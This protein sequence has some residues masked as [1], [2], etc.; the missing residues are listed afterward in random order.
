[1]KKIY[2]SLLVFLALNTALLSK[3]FLITE[4]GAVR[5]QNSTTAIQKAVDECSASGGGRV[6]VPPGLYITG[7]VFL[8]SNVTFHLENG[9]VLKGSTYL[10][11]YRA[12]DTL[13]G[14]FY[15]EDAFNISFTG[16][17]TIDASGTGFYDPTKNHLW[18]EFDRN[19]IRQRNDYMPEGKFFTDGPIKRTGAPGM[20]IVFFHCTK[21]SLRDITIKDTPVW[22]TRFGYCEDVLIDGITILNNILVPNSDGIHCTASRNIRISNC[23]I[24]AGDDAIVLTGFLRDEDNPGVRMAAQESHRYGNKSVYAENLNVTNCQ[25][26]SASAGIRI[27][28]GQHPIRR[29]NFSNITIYDSHRGI[30]IFAHDST[31]IEE[32]IFTNIIIETRLYNGQWWGNGEPIHLSCISRFPGQPAGQIKNVTFNN[33][34]ATGEQGIILFGLKESMIENIAFNNLR[35]HIRIGKET[36]DYGGNF[37]L[38]PATPKAMQI[39]EHDIP[40]IYAQYIRNLSVS[41][42]ELK[43]DPELPDFF[44]NAIEVNEFDN[45]NLDRFHGEASVNSGNKAAIKL[46]NGTGF[47]ISNSDCNWKEPVITKNNVR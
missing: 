28:Y 10:D 44:T 7:V 29:C 33:I 43:W 25:L 31:D 6:M 38:R 34:T 40:G 37:D 2:T 46:T 19:M 21:I 32:L 4:F 3:D 5:G 22:A 24:S 18:D 36:A 13:Y 26:R 30:G 1:M 11:D 16:E 45:L 17:G 47:R 9:A 39:F 23:N 12:G 42:F 8:K 14:M 27:G 15:A 20:T 35:L 41:G